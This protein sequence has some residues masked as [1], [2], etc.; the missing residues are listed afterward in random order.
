MA[1][2]LSHLTGTTYLQPN[3]PS[4]HDLFGPGSIYST[5]IVSSFVCCLHSR[6]SRGE[7]RDTFEP[8]PLLTSL[9]LPGSLAFLIMVRGRT[10]SDDEAEII[11]RMKGRMKPAEIALVVGISERAVYKIFRRIVSTGDFHRPAVDR[12][13]MGRP[14]V[15]TLADLK[16][17]AQLSRVV[18]FI[19]MA[20]TSKRD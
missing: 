6:R 7:K 1:Y 17:S 12:R 20:D 19:H 9:V 15:L 2:W 11:F 4:P 8:Q 5:A 13:R 14:R 16:V 3:H 10:I 18:P